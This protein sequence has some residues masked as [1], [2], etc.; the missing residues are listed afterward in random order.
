MLEESFSKEKNLDYDRERENPAKTL[1]YVVSFSSSKDK[2]YIHVSE[3]SA[4]IAVG[5]ILVLFVSKYEVK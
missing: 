2:K 3:H 1:R 5:V 4:R